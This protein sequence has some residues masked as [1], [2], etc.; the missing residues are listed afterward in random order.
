MQTRAVPVRRRSGDIAARRVVV[1]NLGTVVCLSLSLSVS[2]CLSLMA[3]ETLAFGLPVAVEVTRGVRVQR[4]V[5][6]PVATAVVAK[7][8]VAIAAREPDVS[9]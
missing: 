9:R 5:E 3:L 4:D 7:G 8:G 1:A 2:L 6:R